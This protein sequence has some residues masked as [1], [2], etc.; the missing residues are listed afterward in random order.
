[1]KRELEIVKAEGRFYLAVVLAVFS[2]M[3]A[4][5]VHGGNSRCHSGRTSSTDGRH[6]SPS[7]SWVAPSLGSWEYLHERELSS[8]LATRRHTSK[9]EPDCRLLRECRE[10][11]F[12]RIVSKVNAVMA[13]R[14]RHEHTGQEHHL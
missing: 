10:G 5:L 1:L 6:S 4:R 12:L 13:S 7:R 3:V 14:F 2:R 9:H 11:K 8:T